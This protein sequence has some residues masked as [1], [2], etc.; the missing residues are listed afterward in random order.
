MKLYKIT[1][2]LLLIPLLSFA[3]DGIKHEKSKT[4][5]KSFSVNKNATVYLNN[6]YGNINVTT[7]NKNTVEI[8]VRIIVKGKNL[9]D[10]ERKL[11]AI[12]VLFENSKSL[13]EARTKVESIKSSNWFFWQ[14]NNNINFKIHYDVKMP[15]T[16]NADFHNRYGNI[17]IDKLEGK[18]NI[19][20][21]YGSID[22]G[23]LYNTTNSID[24]D[25][26][27]G[28]YIQYIKS[29][30]ITADYSKITIDEAKDLRVNIDYTGVKIGTVETLN[31]NTDYGG[32]TVN[33]AN[34]VKGSSDYGGMKF[35]TIR[36][37]LDVN[38][39]Y[40]GLRI[41][42]LAKGF[43]KVTI[44]GNYAGIRINTPNDNN[45]DFITDLGYASFKYPKSNVEMYKSIK[46]TTKKYYEGS[47][48]KG[49]SSS[50]I[51]IKSRYGSVSLRTNN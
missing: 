44:N 16:N 1:F 22:L 24:I 43:N 26:C 46:K 19:T 15:I 10:V 40:G 39:D 49:S 47:F 42:N 37:N 14:S 31:F 45:F 5:S 29:G 48:G 36:K 38:T 3:T 7:W 12:N 28:S 9:R 18:S 23:K 13:V 17:D 51:N 30:N 2:L 33:E 25:Y 20:C 4:I 32:I 41:K 50:K 34:N 11:N 27:N 8:D 35:G 6:R 21:K